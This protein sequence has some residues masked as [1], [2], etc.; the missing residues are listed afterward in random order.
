M[1]PPKP[2]AGIDDKK[3]GAVE[4]PPLLK[5]DMPPALPGSDKEQRGVIVAVTPKKD[6]PKDGLPSVPALPAPK[7]GAP[8][9]PATPADGLPMFTPLP[10]PKDGLPSFAPLPEPKDKE[11]PMVPPLGLPT[12][13]K[14]GLPMPPIV[15]VTPK[16]IPKIPPKDLPS[17]PV[18]GAPLPAVRDINTDPYVCVAGDASFGIL[19]QRFYG[20]DKYADAL[21]AYNREHAKWI[22]NGSA[23]LNNP[24]TLAPGQQVERPPVSILE[25]SYRAWIRE[26]NASAA[27]TIPPAKVTITPPVSLGAPPGVAPVSVPPGGAM[28]TYRVQNPNGES[29]FDVAERT[30]GNRSLWPEIWRVNQTNPAVRPPA[31][32]PF[33]TELKLP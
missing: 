31:A 28:K 6:A 7:D 22:K 24:P 26:G 18:G 4:L 25:R 11:V 14:D 23:L 10:A 9:F 16:P 20:S 5:P 17:I 2:L 12:P 29:V 8:A 13:A 3:P 15:D 21:L 33:G 1:P 32:I 30:L 27:P 19:S